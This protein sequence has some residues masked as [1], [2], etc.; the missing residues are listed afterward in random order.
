VRAVAR[1]GGGVVASGGG[2]APVVTG[3]LLS[4]LGFGDEC[5]NEL[6]W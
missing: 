2:L 1:H 4:R 5:G 6:R 3:A